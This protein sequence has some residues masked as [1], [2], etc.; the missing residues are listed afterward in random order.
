MNA[1]PPMPDD[2]GCRT[3]S[4]SAVAHAASTAFPPA[5]SAAT[6]AAEASGWSDATAACRKLA[7]AAAGAP[8]GA[9]NTGSVGPAAS[10][11]LVAATIRSRI[12]PEMGTARVISKYYQA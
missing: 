1:P 7:P 9:G 12:R 5:L 2:D 4:A 10:P 6:P 11:G 3:P 8:A